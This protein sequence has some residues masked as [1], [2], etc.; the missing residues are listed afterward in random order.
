M[1]ILAFWRVDQKRVD[2]H[3]LDE[4]PDSVAFATLWQWRDEL[5]AKFY[6]MDTDSYGDPLGQYGIL[7]ASDFEDA[8]ND[9]E[10]DGGQWMKVMRVGQKEVL[11]VIKE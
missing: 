8:Y 10:L 3:T 9:E 1:T 5:N 2:R 6:N 4:V 7:N 11:N